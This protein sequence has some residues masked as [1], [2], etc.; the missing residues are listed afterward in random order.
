M[1]LKGDLDNLYQ[2]WQEQINNR[3]IDRDDV[4]LALCRK[5]LLEKKLSKQ[6][7]ELFELI[8]NKIFG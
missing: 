7:F 2:T 3:D 5:K 8:I 1:K 6:I 4:F